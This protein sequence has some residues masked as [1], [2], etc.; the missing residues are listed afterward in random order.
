MDIG[1]PPGRRP[2]VAFVHL[3]I[4]LS[5]RK[6][7]RMTHIS[8]CIARRRVANNAPVNGVIKA[9]LLTLRYWME[10]GF[11]TMCLPFWLRPQTGW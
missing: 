5:H 10:D 9:S 1:A 11:G 6:P 3:D 4:I 7:A 2:R 8:S